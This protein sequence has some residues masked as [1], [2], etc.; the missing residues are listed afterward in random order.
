[1]APL[2]ASGL[3]YTLRGNKGGYILGKE[4]QEITLY[5][6]INPV[7]GSLAPVP[8]VDQAGFCAR[9]GFCAARQVWV[10][11]KEKIIGELKSISLSDLVLRQ[12]QNRQP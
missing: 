7:E 9:S 10:D 4:P 5:D 11:L 8:C 12:E 2:R 3:I 1:M 6:V